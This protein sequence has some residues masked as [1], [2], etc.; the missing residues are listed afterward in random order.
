MDEKEKYRFFISKVGHIE[1]QIY[2]YQ[3]R[4]KVFFYWE[5]IPWFS[6]LKYTIKNILKTANEM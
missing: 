2:I 4:Y 6:C 5:E 1:L 3:Q